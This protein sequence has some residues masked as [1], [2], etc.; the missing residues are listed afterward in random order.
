M[1]YIYTSNIKY[2]SGA[3]NNTKEYFAQKVL[4][5]IDD[6]EN[7][8]LNAKEY[9]FDG[10]SVNTDMYNN[11]SYIAGGFSILEIGKDFNIRWGTLEG[12]KK[13]KGI[14]SYIYFLPPQN[15]PYKI[16]F[17]ANS[18]IDNTLTVYVNNNKIDTFNIHRG[19]NIFETKLI[20]FNNILKPCILKLEHSASF[21]PKDIDSTSL[22]GRELTLAYK[23]I[24][25]K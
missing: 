23:Q 4:F 9:G 25:L 22:D 16:F 20:N 17:D 19:E 13:S 3:L 18:E 7:I 8:L 10:I 6:I 24:R 5:D 15:K 2:S 21:S 12:K 1:P 14:N 11:N